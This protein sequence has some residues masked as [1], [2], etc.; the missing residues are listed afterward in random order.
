[1]LGSLA[2]QTASAL[3]RVKIA[4]QMQKEKAIQNKIL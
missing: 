1:L 3:E 4:E 2:I